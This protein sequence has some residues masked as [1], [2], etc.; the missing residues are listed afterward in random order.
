MTVGIVGYTGFIGTNLVSYLDDSNKV[1]RISLRET[2]WRE[3]LG[4]VDVV[5]NLVGKAHD[6][7]GISTEN[8]YFLA[9]YELTKNIFN[10]FLETEAKLFIHVSSIAA[11][12]EMESDDYLLE[13]SV[14][15]PISFY[16]KSKRAAE[17]WLLDQ[18]LPFTKKLLVLRPPMVHGAGD[19]GNLGLLYNLISKGIPYPLSAFDN[20]RSFISIDNF[21]FFVKEIID[22]RDN[23]LSGIYHIADDEALSTQDIIHV[24]KDQINK[25]VINISIPK[26]II[27]L[28]ARLGDRFSF[29]LNSKRLK[30]MTGNLLVSNK[31]LK[32]GLGISMLPMSAKS[33]L[34]KTIKS[35]VKNNY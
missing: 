23:S 14:C 5:I 29:P 30:K 18:H 31:K 22:R 16:G 35:F 32:E 26:N 19:K 4:E 21:C 8:D 33:G 12:E 10:A 11:V 20:K 13:D 7:K 9:N 2:N 28:I 25:R 24:I 27:Y 6:H 17:V 34:Q 15:S 1:V 3:K